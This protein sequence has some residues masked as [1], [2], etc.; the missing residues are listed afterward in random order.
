[1]FHSENIAETGPRWQR[2]PGQRLGCAIQ[3]E[4]STRGGGELNHKRSLPVAFG[5]H[6]RCDCEGDGGQSHRYGHSQDVEEE[7][8]PAR[9][10]VDSIMCTEKPTG[11]VRNNGIDSEEF[12]TSI[13]STAQWLKVLDKA[14]SGCSICKIDWAT[15]IKHIVLQ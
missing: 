8:V 5:L 15:A 12:P 7:E 9:S 6:A 3:A 11:A 1:M 13:S 2:K 4:G 10:K 14:E